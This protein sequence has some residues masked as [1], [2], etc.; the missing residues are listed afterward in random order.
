MSTHESNPTFP[1]IPRPRVLITAGPTR[2]PIDDVRFIGNRSS[3]A[4][5]IELAR[6]AATLGLPTTLALGES[7]QNPN[8]DNISIER[9]D[10]TRELEQLLARLM[11]QTDLLVMAAAVADHTPAA[12]HAGKLGRNETGRTSIEL[13]PT[14]DLLAAVAA[15]A[16]P[17]QLLVGFA[18]EPADRL[19]ESAQRKL[20][21]KRVDLI[22]ANPLDTM[23]SGTITATLVAAPH[24]AGAVDQPEPSKTKQAFAEWLWPVLL[25]CHQQKANR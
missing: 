7:V 6:S 18:L 24:L 13:V 10:E 3:G 11:P 25:A 9:F 17:D 22:I 16:R 19:A 5:G 21:S 20:E 4:L 2:E 12:R 23:E 14:P 15:T 8:I 1:P